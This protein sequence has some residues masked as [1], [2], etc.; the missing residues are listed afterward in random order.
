[1][2]PYYIL[3]IGFI[4]F[5]VILHFIDILKLYKAYSERP[6][7]YTKQNLTMAIVK[8]IGIDAICILLA[9]LVLKDI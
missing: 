3:T 9:Y 2:T 1:M 8:Y 5:V 7:T 6:N 4:S